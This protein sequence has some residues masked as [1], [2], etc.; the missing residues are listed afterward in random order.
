MRLARWMALLLALAA[1]V[2]AQPLTNRWFF[3]SRN[4]QSDR[5]VEDFR[6]LARIASTHGLNGVM[7]SAN[8]D[9]LDRQGEAYR[10][11]LAE[12]RQVA[13]ENA[14]EIVPL[15][16]SAGYAGGI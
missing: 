8:F 4:L 5:D 1:A 14:I 2:D 13:A 16:Y 6:E 15:F 3:Y 11:R 9:N 12:I 10:R 7:L